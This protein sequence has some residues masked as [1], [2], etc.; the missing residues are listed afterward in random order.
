M[1]SHNIS[2]LFPSP[3]ATA[4]QNARVWMAYGTAKLEV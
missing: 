4:V 3:F 2:V 1:N